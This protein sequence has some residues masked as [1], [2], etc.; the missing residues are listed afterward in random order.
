MPSLSSS[1]SWQRYARV[2]GV[3]SVFVF[4]FLLFSD[5]S[6]QCCV[7]RKVKYQAG[8]TP[9]TATEEESTVEGCRAVT[10]LEPCTKKE[11]FV[12]VNF[13]SQPCPLGTRIETDD[14]GQP[15]TVACVPVAEI[16][17][18]A[19]CTAYNQCLPF[20][21]GNPESEQ[22]VCREL[23][24]TECAKVPKSCFIVAGNRCESLFDESLCGDLSKTDCDASQACAYAAGNCSKRV[25]GELA[26]RYEREGGLLPPCAYA[27]NCRDINDVVETVVNYGHKLFGIMGSFAFVFFIIGGIT[28]LTSFGNA[29]RVKKGQM[30]LT[31]AV[32]GIVIAFSAY[33]LIDFLLDAL[34]VRES[35]RP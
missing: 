4:V 5:A 35:F 32:V 13:L 2:V 7:T 12:P 11:T 25:E 8:Q 1:Y 22:F 30:M 18:P 31:A 14:F 34:S 15:D 33:F 9:S 23:S 19:D 16:Q 27:G 17:E 3:A 29:E 24:A 26:K 28:I 20:V 10:T 21:A 6:A